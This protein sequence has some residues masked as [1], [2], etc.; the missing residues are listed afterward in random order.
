MTAL[1]VY[2]EDELLDHLLGEGDRDFASPET[3]YVALFTAETAL[4]TNVIGSAS[5]V[6]GGAYARE[7]VSFD[8]ASGGS[9]S[10][11]AAVE[12]DPASASWGTIT[13]CAIMDASTAGNVL[14]WGLL[15][16]SKVIGIGDQF[17]FAIGNLTVSLE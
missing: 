7:A 13:H 16:A 4:E 11:T 1:S 6:S 14:V 8:A 2:T 12:W 9:A 3:L 5:E 17:K 15:S 10:N